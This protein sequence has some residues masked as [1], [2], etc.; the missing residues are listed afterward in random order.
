M[1]ATDADNRRSGVALIITLGLLSILTVLAVAFAIAMRVERVAARNYANSVRAEGL[2]H[3]ALVRALEDI[4]DSMLNPKTNVYPHW[5]NRHP[6]TVLD[7][8]GSTATTSGGACLPHDC[9]DLLTGEASTMIPESLRRAATEMARHGNWLDIAATNGPVVT[10]HGRIAYLALNCSGLIDV[11]TVGGARTR[12]WS[13]NVQEIKLWNQPDFV[14]SNAVEQFYNNRKRDVR[15]ETLTE[16]AALNPGVI[17]SVSN[18]FYYS[19]DPGRDEFFVTAKGAQWWLNTDTAIPPKTMGRRTALLQQKFYINAITNY[20][21]Y[22]NPNDYNSYARDAA[23]MANYYTPL[24]EM[25]GKAGHRAA[26]RRGL[27]HRQLP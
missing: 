5:S 13:T 26:G 18:L 12:H 24:M 8:M 10:K 9:T 14:N 1:R 6:A 7:A 22:N 27:E 20:A 11:N 21:G 2:I 17:R 4:D 3:A 19:Y 25:L 23:F 15:Y 16:L